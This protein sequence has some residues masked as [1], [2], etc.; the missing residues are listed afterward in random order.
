MPTK[1]GNFTLRELHSLLSGIPRN[2]LA[3]GRYTLKQSHW[4]K[5]SRKDVMRYLA[6][7]KKREQ[8]P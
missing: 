5:P 3:T 2:Q 7:Q 1:K 4:F 8:K 6:W